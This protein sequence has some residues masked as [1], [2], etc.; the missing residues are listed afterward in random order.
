MNALTPALRAT[1]KTTHSHNCRV[2]GDRS[3]R[4]RLWRLRRRGLEHLQ[5]LYVGAAEHD[6]IEHLVRRRNLVCSAAFP[7]LGTEGTDW[8]RRE[9]R[10]RR[11]GTR[12]DQ[13]SCSDTVDSCW[14]MECNVPTYRMSEREMRE[15]LLPTYGAA[16][17]PEGS[18][19][20]RPSAVLARIRPSDQPCST[21]KRH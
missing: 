11:V 13:P 18:C 19:A 3:R 16:I 4:R 20:G 21:R 10:P 8:S 5:V 9:K 6:E 1:A 15:I 17:V 2:I 14:L 12:R 7:A